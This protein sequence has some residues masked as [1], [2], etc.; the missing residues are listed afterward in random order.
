MSKNPE[1]LKEH[2]LENLSFTT[3]Q[4]DCVGFVLKDEILTNYAM[5][6]MDYKL[7]EKID[8]IRPQLLEM[9][10]LIKDIKNHIDN[11]SENKK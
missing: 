6:T 9:Y 10:S 7:Q 8:K 5:T 1:N 3:K 4:L 11:E 2:A